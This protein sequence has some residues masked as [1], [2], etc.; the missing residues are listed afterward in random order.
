MKEL[1]NTKKSG[2]LKIKEAN[3]KLSDARNSYNNY[4]SSYE[5]NLNRYNELTSE[6]NSLKDA[7]AACE[8]PDEAAMYVE[9]YQAKMM[10]I[11]AAMN[12]YETAYNAMEAAKESISMYETALESEKI[13]V[14]GEIDAAQYN[15]DT[16]SLTENSSSDNTKKLEELKESLENTKIKA[17]K[18]GVISMINAEEGKTCQNGIIMSLQSVSDV[19]VHV[20]ISE[21]DML[22]VKKG[23]KA[24]VTIPARKDDEYTGS[25]DR[26]IDIKSEQ[27]FDGY[28]NIDDTENFRIGMNAKVKITTVDEP[29]V[30]S[31]KKSAIFKND[32]DRSC[33]YEAEKQSD[34]T[35]KIRE[36][37][38]EEGI[39]KELYTAVTGDGLEE[40]D[41]IVLNPAKCSDGDVVDVRLQKK[42]KDEA[43]DSND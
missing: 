15:I 14:K 27:G 41:Y 6:A 18:S 17:D 20:T 35:Y 25:V 33:V 42:K 1:E 10:E 23:M 8:N 12:A 24:V 39:S 2:D 16:Y 19:C 38:V 37:E 22:S 29:E 7:A 5:N 30:L 43:G 11:S 3:D 4:K 32:D 13:S 34:G 26:V 36:V 28:I 21:E 40:G 9:Q 31:V